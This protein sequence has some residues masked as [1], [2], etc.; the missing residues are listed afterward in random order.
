MKVSSKRA[1]LSALTAGILSFIFFLI[2]WVVGAWFETFAITSL[3][4]Q[5]L[6]GVLIWGVLVVLFHQR[7]L[8]EREKLD[9]AHWRK[10]TTSRLL[11]LPQGPTGV[12]CLRLLSGD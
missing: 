12:H 1:E 7:S 11:S 5:I 10:V 8:A 6:G 3:S 9:M 2:T 4:F